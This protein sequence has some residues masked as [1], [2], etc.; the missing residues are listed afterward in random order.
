MFI[1]YGIVCHVASKCKYLFSLHFDK[2]GFFQEIFLE[3]FSLI[4]RHHFTTEGLY[5]SPILGTFSHWAVKVL[6]HVTLSVKRAIR[7]EWNRGPATLTSLVDGA[8][9]TC[10][11]DFGLSWR[12]IELRSPAC[13]ERVLRIEPPRRSMN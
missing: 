12:G 4:W 6:Y 7:L 2:S 5:D 13:E 11:Y 1:I 8:V 9:T 10:F 3:K